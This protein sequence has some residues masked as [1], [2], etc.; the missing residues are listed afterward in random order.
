MLFSVR[1]MGVFV[2]APSI[3]LIP[4]SLKALNPVGNFSVHAQIFS[5]GGKTITV[6][7]SQVKYVNNASN[8]VND[9]CQSWD[10]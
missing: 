4:P 2:G 5:L 6:I 3:F 9:F 7:Y 8:Y 10:S 1:K